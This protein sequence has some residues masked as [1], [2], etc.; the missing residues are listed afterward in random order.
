M[1][2]NGNTVAGVPVITKRAFQAS[3]TMGVLFLTIGFVKLCVAPLSLFKI[4]VPGTISVSIPS[5]HFSI[6]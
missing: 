1:V 4:V 5:L 6:C 3:G 2:K